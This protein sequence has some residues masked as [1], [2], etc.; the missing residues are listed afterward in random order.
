M[1]GV[2]KTEKDETVYKGFSTRHI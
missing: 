2:Q 1:C